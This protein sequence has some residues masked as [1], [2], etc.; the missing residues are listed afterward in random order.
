MFIDSHCHLAYEPLI[1]NIDKILVDCKKKNI[2]KILT[3]GTNL[4][5]SEISSDLSFK[6]DEIYSSI[7]IHPNETNNNSENIL[8]IKD[9]YKKNIKNIAYGE[10]GLDYYYSKDRRSEQLKLFES[11][12]DFAQEDN[13]T[14]IVHTRDAETDTAAIINNSIKFKKVNFLI[15]CFT[16]TIDFAK[17]LLN[18]GCYISF[19]G[20][21]TFKNSH[22]LQN[23]VKYIPLDR[24][25]IE[26]DS[27]F[28]SPHPYRGEKNSPANLEYVAKKVAEIKKISYDEV[29]IKTSNN[30]YN[31]FNL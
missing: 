16:G 18:M 12:I 21:I 14:V 17:I 11:H 30:F 23:V 9:I 3:I 10:T 24:M 7:G 4:Q 31:I 25:L 1:E 13:S 20:I 26:T 19:S 29:G 8:K 5:T 22:D 2:N 28:L 6:H 27:P 15:H